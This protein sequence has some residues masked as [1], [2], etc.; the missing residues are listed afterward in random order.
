MKRLKIYL[1]FLFAGLSLSALFSC[2]SDSDGDA[3]LLTLS[4]YATSVQ[5]GDI[6]DVDVNLSDKSGVD[7]IE[8]KKTQ[9]GKELDYNKSIPVAETTFPFKFKTEV[10]AEDVNGATVYSFYAK[11]ASGKSIDAA[12][13]VMEVALAQIPLLL[14]YDWKLVSQIVKGE[15]MATEDMLDDVNRFNPDLTWELDW[16][17]V[18]SASTLETL[19]STCSWKAVMKGSVVDSLYTIKYNVFA[20]NVPIV[21]KYKVLQLAKRTLKLESRQDLSAFGDYAADER[22]VETFEPISKTDDFTPY[23]NANPDSYVNGNCNPGSY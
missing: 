13:L 18:L 20:P 4:K 14:K 11:N 3:N 16:G 5:I 2:S 10:T 7:K 6:L 15:D 22:V 8:I 19:F 21:T 23:R 1:L 9:D 17:S 12:D